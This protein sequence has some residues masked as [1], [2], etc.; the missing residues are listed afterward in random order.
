LLRLESGNGQ[1]AQVGTQLPSPLVVS[2]ENDAGNPLSG[3]IVNFVVTSGG[4]SVFAGASVTNAEGIAQE[5]WTLGL[6][7][8]E[9]QRVEVR[10][11]DPTTGEPKIFGVFEA[12]ALPGPVASIAFPE[13]PDGAPLV[14]EHTAVPDPAPVTAFDAYG[15]PVPGVAVT[16]G[17]H[18]GSGTLSGADQVTDTHGQARVGEWIIGSVG[19][20]QTI[21]AEAEPLGP[22]LRA[23]YS[24]QAVP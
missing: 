21:Y 16:F 22:T 10:A 3:Q 4:G 14:P 7:T 8:A 2:A 1:E 15:N 6:S 19:E 17:I 9:P 24:V 23:F 5:L 13:T 12:T 20:P 18:D 11:V